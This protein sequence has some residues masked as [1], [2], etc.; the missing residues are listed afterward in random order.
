[1]LHRHKQN[2]GDDYQHLA[3]KLQK[4]LPPNAAGPG[5]NV[6]CVVDKDHPTSDRVVSIRNG[7]NSQQEGGYN[8]LFP[9]PKHMTAYFFE[10]LMVF[11]VSA[12]FL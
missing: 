6:V 11:D 2:D 10:F 12:Q 7:S 9:L 4:Y 1:M 3:C 5:T 8:A